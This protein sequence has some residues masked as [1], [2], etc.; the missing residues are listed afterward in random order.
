NLVSTFFELQVNPVNDPPT[1][2]AIPNQVTAQDVPV[3]V[4]FSVD[5]VESPAIGLIVS[6][7]SSSQSVV[8]NANLV[9]G[10]SGANRTLM[11]TPGTN[12]SGSS[13]ITVQV[14]D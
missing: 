9:L 10:G 13:V 14:N 6:A 2:S 11:I 5:D 12:A 8:P 1:L 7:S 3:T 4:S